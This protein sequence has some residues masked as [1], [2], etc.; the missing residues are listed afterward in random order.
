MP[1]I[2]PGNV[3]L[4]VDTDGLSILADVDRILSTRTTYIY[5]C[6]IAIL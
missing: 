3:W 5:T 2:G 6:G 4:H 1:E